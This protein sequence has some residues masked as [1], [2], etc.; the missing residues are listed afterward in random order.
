[1]IQLPY[2]TDDE[3]ARAA[4]FVAE[5]FRQ[6][7]VFEARVKMGIMEVELHGS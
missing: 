5:L 3:I 1:M 4:K 7:L 2:E 6:G